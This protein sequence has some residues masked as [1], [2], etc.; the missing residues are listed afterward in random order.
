MLVMLTQTVPTLSAPTSAPVK[1]VIL[2]MGNRVKVHKR[3]L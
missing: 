1:K 3:S 2:K